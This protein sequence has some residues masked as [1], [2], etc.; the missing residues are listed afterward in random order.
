[1]PRI[2]DFNNFKDPAYLGSM[3]DSGAEE[4][5]RGFSYETTEINA[6][7]DLIYCSSCGQNLHTF[8]DTDHIEMASAVV[9]FCPVCALEQ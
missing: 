8:V 5:E 1:M 6:R 9:A 2:T 7:L 3:D 4:S